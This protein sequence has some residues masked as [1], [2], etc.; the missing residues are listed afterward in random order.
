[1]FAIIS[2][3]KT[4]TLYWLDDYRS[5]NSG[6]FTPIQDYARHD[7]HCIQHTR[8]LFRLLHLSRNCN[9]RFF[10]NPQAETPP[11]AT[12]NKSTC[13]AFTTTL[14][15]HPNKHKDTKLSGACSGYRERSIKVSANDDYIRKSMAF[16]I[17]GPQW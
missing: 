14:P 3:S 4:N 5:Q 8:S 15:A 9:A 10:L 13:A 2:K 7:Y 11:K 17:Q 1:M 12:G 6:S 16:T